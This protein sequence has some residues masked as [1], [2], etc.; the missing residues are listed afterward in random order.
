MTYTHILAHGNDSEAV[1]KAMPS[2][3]DCAAVAEVFKLISDG[4]RLRIL[5][6]LCH[7]E[8]SVGDI[9]E[10]MDMSNPAVSHHLRILKKSGIISSRVVLWTVAGKEK[11]YSTDWLTPNRQSLSTE[12]AKPCST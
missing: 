7:R 2:V 5:W 9:A 1:K 4:S 10:M 6:L 11:K 3:D 12:P 8:V